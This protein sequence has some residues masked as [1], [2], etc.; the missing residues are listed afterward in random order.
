MAAG[1]LD[2]NLVPITDAAHQAARLYV[3]VTVPLYAIALAT[4]IARI[5][6]KL[7]SS[8]RLAVD[9]YLIIIGFVSAI[10]LAYNIIMQ[11]VLEQLADSSPSSSQPATGSS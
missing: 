5:A 7:R 11:V 3:G 9:D 6:F 10:H 4:L 2:P 1:S 8:V